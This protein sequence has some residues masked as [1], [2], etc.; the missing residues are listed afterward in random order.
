M[1]FLTRLFFCTFVFIC[2]SCEPE[3]LPEQTVINN[4]GDVYGDTGNEGDV[5]DEKGTKGT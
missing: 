1:K 4:D 2:F 5:N 3:E